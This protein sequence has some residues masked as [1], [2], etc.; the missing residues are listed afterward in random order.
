MVDEE[1]IEV[2]N[3]RGYQAGFVVSQ[4]PAGNTMAQPG[5]KIQLTVS[6]GFVDV[7]LPIDLP[8]TTTAVDLQV[9]VN[10]ELQ[11]PSELGVDNLSYLLPS[12]KKTITLTLTAQQENYP[13]TVRIAAADT[14]N[15][16]VYK[17]FTVNGVTGE[18]VENES[19]PFN[20]PYK[21]E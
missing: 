18:A 15:F 8:D 7:Q 9:Y 21:I 6:S 3:E 1:A 12:D 13:V 14:G 10:G 19:H 4:T 17:S 11:S 16:Q 2:V 20:D 5:T